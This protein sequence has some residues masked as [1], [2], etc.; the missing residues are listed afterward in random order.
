MINDGE[1]G[2]VAFAFGERRNQVHRHHL[3]GERFWGHWDFVEGDA[4][5][6]CQSFILLAYR[7]PFDVIRNPLVHPWPPVGLCYLTDGPISARVSH[8]WGVMG[9]LQQLSS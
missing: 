2:I 6:M 3:E 8:L 7:T 9:C 1:D 4:R 5:P